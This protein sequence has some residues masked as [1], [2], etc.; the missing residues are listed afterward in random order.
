[1]KN[2][3]NPNFHALYH[4]Q[5]IEGWLLGEMTIKPTEEEKKQD[6]NITLYGDGEQCCAL[7]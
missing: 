3:H 6:K 1:M 4:C 7:Q 5:K 2:T